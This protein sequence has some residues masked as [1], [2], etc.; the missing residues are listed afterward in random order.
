MAKKMKKI[1]LFRKQSWILLVFLIPLILSLLVLYFIFG[2]LFDAFQKMFQLRGN[3]SRTADSIA[4]LS[5]VGTIL[6]ALYSIVTTA[7]F[8]YLV[9][10]VSIRS[11]QVSN[12]LK[13]LEENRDKEVVR[14]QALIVYY[15]LQR[16]FS[17]LRD[18]YI[19]T[20]NKGISPNPKRLFFSNEWIKNVATLRNGLSNEDLNIVYQ[21]YNDF[22]TLQSLLENPLDNSTDQNDELSRVIKGMS[23]RYFAD[24][25]PIQVLEQYTNSSTDDFLEINF[26]IIL[27]KIYLLT[28]PEN[29]VV[30]K[31]ETEMTSFDVMINNVHFY[32]VLSGNL[33]DGEGILYTANGYK[34]AEGQFTK[35]LFSTGKVYGYFDN[36]LKHY[37]IKYETIGPRRRIIEGELIEPNGTEQEQYYFKGQ[38]QNGVISTGISTEFHSNGTVSFRGNIENGIREGRGTAYLKDGKILFK[39]L[40][41]QDERSQGT[42][43]HK[44][45]E[46]F[47]GE[48]REGRPWT[49]K[50]TNYN[51]NTEKVKEFTGEIREGKPYSG[52]GI[53]LKRN[54]FGFDLEDIIQQDNWEPDDNMWEHMEEQ[55]DYYNEMRNK[56]TRREYSDWED[57]IKVDW[58]KGEALEREDIEKNL[59]VYFSEHNKR[60][61]N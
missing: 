53:R 4:S 20:V 11:F 42:L 47:V 5:D 50:V 1:T 6:L 48:F 19:S 13:S 17:Y 30:K 28:F 3:P 31:Q 55:E 32:S 36:V 54:E 9:W 35:G 52:T 39:G 49:G 46:H 60:E 21:M 44:G 45:K 25:F 14:E 41:E 34:K 2:N 18:L 59:T 23:E 57:Y 15:D 43:Y 40:Y 37:L 33:W 12:E 26:Y 16:G 8:S 10:K 51:F 58:K 56:K 7:I 24:F 61:N 38:F 22:F 29:Q 27:Q